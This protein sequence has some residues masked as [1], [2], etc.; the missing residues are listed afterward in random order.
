MSSIGEQVSDL[1]LKEKRAVLST[2]LGE[3]TDT[4][5]TSP[6]SFAQQRL[7]FLAQLEPDNPSYNLRQ[8]LR[9]EGA[10]DVNALEQTIN[11]IIA[12]HEALR[13]TFKMVDGEPVQVVSSLHEIDL[14]FANLE[15]L[16]EAERETEA[17]RLANAEAWSLFDLSCDYPLRAKLVRL[18]HDHHWLLL[19]MHHIAGDGWSMGILSRELSKIYE[20]ITTNQP[21]ELP[22]L[23][24]QYAD[25]A[26]W[27][28]EWLQGAVF[29]EQLNYWTSNLAGAP[30]ELKLPTDR[31]R[32]PQQSFRGA[33]VSLK[34]PSELSK[35]IRDFSQR[36]GVTVFMTMLAAFQ[37]LL[38][39][40]TGHADIVVGSP[41]AGRNR[42]EIENLIGFFVNTLALRTSFS[43]NPSFR[44]LLDRVKEVTLGAYAN[45]D[46]PFEELVRE[47]NPERDANH[48]PV[49][50]V[51]FGMQNEAPP[52]LT[53]HGLTISRVPVPARTA[54]YDL[55]LYAS[56]TETGLVCWFEYSLDLF[57]EATI[58]RMLGHLETLLQAAVAKPDQ[59]VSD[60]PLLTEAERAQVLEWNHTTTDYP[61]NACVHE[62]FEGQVQRTPKNVA[63]L[64][65]DEQLTY[66]HLNARANQLAHYLQKRG[67]R[68]GSLVGICVERSTAMIVAMLG[69][70]KAGAAYV[71]LDLTYPK[72]RLALMLHDSQARVLLTQE[73]LLDR[74][75]QHE[76][77]V[78]C[79]DTDRE[80]IHA[81]SEENSLSGASADDLAYVI[82]TSGSTGKPKGV[83]VPHRAINRLVNNTNYIKLSTAD[84]VAQASTASF[85]AATFEVWGALLNGARLVG[86]PRNVILSPRDF[87]AKL[88]EQEVSAIFLTT[89]LFNQ[90]A[91]EVPGVFSS[92]R[93]VLFGGEAVDPKWVKEVL[94]NGPPKR[95]LHVYGPTENTTFSTWYLVENVPSDA[96][97]VP[98]G[99]AISNTQLYVLDANLQLVP[100]GIPGELYISGDGLAREYL[101]DPELTTKRFIP[102]PFSVE[103]G[104]KLY[105][106]GDLVRCLPDGNL[107]FL[108]RVDQQVKLRGYRIELGEIET[109]MREH[110]FVQDAVV[111]VGNAEDNKTLVGY[112]VSSANGHAQS[113]NFEVE[114]KTFLKTKLPD[115]MVP[116][117]FVF[118]ENLP[119]SPGGKI[120][121]QSLP[122][123]V[124]AR[125]GLKDAHVAPRNDVEKRLAQIFE[126]V[127]GVEDVGVRDNFFDLG[128]HS[129]LAVRLVSEM[130]KDF[131]KRLPLVS[132]FEGANIE[133]LASLLREDVKSRA[134]PTLVEIQGKGENVPL[135]CVSMPNVN[136]LGYRTLA[137]YLGTNQPVFGLQAQYP[138]DL[139]GEHSQEA[140]D[141]IAT[142]YLEALRAM[143]PKGP[144]QFVGLCRGAHIAYEMA[145]RLEQQGEKVALLGILDTWVVENTYSIFF[146]LEHY[147]DRLRWLTRQGFRNQV[148]FIR[149]YARGAMMRQRNPLHEVYFPGPNFVPR[150]YNGRIAVFRARKQPRQ[151]IRDVSLGWGKLALAGVDVYFIPGGHT[152][153]LQEPYVEGLAAELKKCLME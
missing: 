144:Y 105:R 46:F 7:W 137:R 122:A 133:Y 102:N 1:P 22:E 135:F 73:R 141:N 76:A 113:E 42:V 25:F 40:Y 39:R 53:L 48:S 66:E 54:K 75:P 79:L 57:E 6:L 11:H 38:Y 112:I 68:P 147:A 16:P 117:Q 103:P 47:I 128:G 153:V 151:R 51:M 96:T 81:E 36:E 98:I 126:R 93:T 64:F 107:E 27:Q 34:L 148:S 65:D 127:L 104:A 145:R 119:I 56:Q 80:K 114:L 131:G 118:L 8:T 10:L 94:G 139:E 2:L 130:E 35:S 97:T 72:D 111:T 12:R 150:T 26:E 33:S 30:P 31:P 5:V 74:L 149:K 101:N 69:I 110:P 45:Q 43:G 152:S 124:G 136:A 20:S 106:T 67:V 9:L 19:T 14:I 115:Y 41:I 50:Q 109:I 55:T 95:L 138:E 32:L 83:A 140:V 89:A 84:N 123:P 63:V 70:L 49:F 3:E 18:D 85:D 91:S 90:I 24:V 88:R 59:R 116:A 92:V 37:T 77:E 132:F 71:P 52:P 17:Q 134:W 86:F 78:I 58:K 15:D 61:N 60:L 23:P 87:A 82:Y 62:L 99:R 44:D 146:Y 121:R 29:E 100:V 13:T 28:R 129:L 108:S 143:R 4:A 125:P 21:V 142:E 120:D